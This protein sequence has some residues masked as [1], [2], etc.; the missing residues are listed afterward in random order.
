MH[1]NNQG[2]RDERNYGQS[3]RHGMSGRGS[4]E[5]WQDRS[6]SGRHEQDE[7]SSDRGRWDRG[8]QDRFGDRERSMNQGSQGYQGSPGYQG[9]QVCHQS[10]RHH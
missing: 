3:D 6:M 8:N 4:R 7:F 9:Q 5:D 1:S 2:S 10:H